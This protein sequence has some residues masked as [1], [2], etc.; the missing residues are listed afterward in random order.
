MTGRGGYIG[1]LPVSEGSPLWHV[2]PAFADT[3]VRHTGNGH[4]AHML[5]TDVDRPPTLDLF[6]HDA[7]AVSTDERA[8]NARARELLSDHAF[9][10]PQLAAPMIARAAQLVAAAC[11]HDQLA[12]AHAGQ[13]ARGRFLVIDKDS[14]LL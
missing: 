14:P 4:H 9:S 2:V 10:L 6:F 1:R 5:M 12:H 13:W 8:G 3:Q 11:R 7:S